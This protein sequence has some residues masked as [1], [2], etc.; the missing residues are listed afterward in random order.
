[1]LRTKCLAWLLLAL[2][3]C[4]T[5]AAGQ[6]GPE[7]DAEALEQAVVEATA[8]TAIQNTWDQLIQNRLDEVTAINEQALSVQ[9]SLSR[10][11]N[12]L[13][14]EIP[15]LESEFNQLAAIAQVN[16]SMP[17]DLTVIVER[18]RRLG[19]QANA[20]AA[21]LENSMAD[22]TDRLGDLEALETDIPESA[23]GVLQQFTNALDNTTQ[24][25]TQLQGRV[26]SILGPVTS[27]R[28]DM[29]ELQQR[30]EDAMPLLWRNYYLN[31]AGKI[32]D[33]VGWS[34]E[35]SRIQTL[36]DVLSLRLSTEFP[37]TTREWLFVLLRAVVAALVLNLV[38]YA[39]RNS[40]Q[41]TPEILQHGLNR[42]VRN[43]AV[44]I[45]LGLSLQYAA[46]SAGKMFQI[47]STLGIMS[48]AWAQMTL[49]WD[50]RAFS[51]PDQQRM[52]PL[53]PMF[54]ALILGI[55]LLYLDPFPLF[56]SVS[57]LLCLAFFIW[58]FFKRK[59]SSTSLAEGL[60]TGFAVICWLA[61]ILTLFGLA[62]ISI[63]LCLAYTVIAVWIQQSVALVNLGNRLEE[64]LP[65]EGMRALLIRLALSLAVP[66]ILIVLTFL[67]VFWLLAYPGGTY[68]LS[69]VSRMGFNVGEVSFNAMQVL[70][71]IIGFFATRSL[72]TVGH[73]FINGLRKEGVQMDSGIVSPL[74]TAYTYILWSIFILFV[75]R[76]LGFNLTSLA[77]VAGGLSVGVGF[78]LQNIIQNFISGLMVIF[79]KVIKEGDEVEVAGVSGTVRRVNIRST[80]LET[81]D[82]GIVFI[83]NSNFLSNTF[84]NWTHNNRIVRREISIGVGYATDLA[85]A[86]KLLVAAARATPKVMAYPSPAV[87]VVDLGPGTV[88]LL[89]RYWISDISDGMGTLT[90]IRLSIKQ[91]FA[92]HGIELTFPQEVDVKLLKQESKP[93]QILNLEDE[94]PKQE[95]QA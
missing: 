63:L 19:E 25:V 53:A 69:Y 37:Q 24:L 47:F 94:P 42:I 56:L 86:M 89:L 39:I 91:S 77:V 88:K 90:Q 27:L 33:P 83:P 70:G 36:P 54:L 73:A 92:E 5:Q 20:L 64:S 66:A 59:P 50:L 81:G 10:L 6:M 17:A 87:Y 67:P 21:P 15:A 51:N 61:V 13:F 43:S 65:S 80:Q 57:W 1:M 18:I 52:S 68:L 35:L 14:R 58:R 4:A 9:S 82:N 16:R 48:L 38:L 55:V 22:L 31:P 40:L 72:I 23:S 84:T 41:K 60:L 11:S 3:G 71:V 46:W 78:G 44:W 49:A 34:S 45:A 74:Q 95:K 7:V 2:L 32:F 75:L 62:R 85:E 26:S 76:T 79:G 8:V 29:H 93:L 30:I 12:S 28:E